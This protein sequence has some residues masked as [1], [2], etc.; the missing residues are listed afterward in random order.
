MDRPHKVILLLLSIPI[1]GACIVLLDGSLFGPLSSDGETILSYVMLPALLAV[2]YSLLP[3]QIDPM[4][5][6][7]K[8]AWKD[9]WEKGVSREAWI[10]RL[11]VAT[12]IGKVAIYLSILAAGFVFIPDIM[13]F[14][15]I[16]TMLGC[17]LG[18][19]RS[20]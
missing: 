2:P 7:E 4:S 13:L 16:F 1:I 19:N 15:A 18:D 20:F 14:I 5:D 3:S 8:K 10:S 12:S 9:A 11:G 17:C 6:E